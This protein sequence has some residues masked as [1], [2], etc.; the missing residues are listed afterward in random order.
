MKKESRKR[1]LTALTI[2]LGANFL[3]FLT[4]WN[5][6]NFAKIKKVLLDY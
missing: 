2:L 5:L 6:Q 3:F 4:V 1:Q